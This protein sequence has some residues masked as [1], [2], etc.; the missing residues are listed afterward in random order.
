MHGMKNDDVMLL[1]FFF[2]LPILTLTMLQEYNAELVEYYVQQKESKV[3]W[4]EAQDIYEQSVF[5]A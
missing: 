5:V 3:T 4:L 2:L 1:P